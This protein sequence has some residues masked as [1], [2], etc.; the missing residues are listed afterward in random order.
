M[1]TRRECALIEFAKEVLNILESHEEWDGDTIDDIGILAINS[2]LAK[3][4]DEGLFK[5]KQDY[6]N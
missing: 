6:T 3:T 4:D 5:V 2:G 1:I